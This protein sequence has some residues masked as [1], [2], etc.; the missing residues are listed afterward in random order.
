MKKP[1]LSLLS[2]IAFAACNNSETSN[3]DV[4]SVANAIKPPSN[5]QYNIVAT[6]PHDTASYTQGL[7]WQNNTLYEGTGLEGQSRLLKVDLANGKATQEISLDPSVFGEGITILNDKI[8]QLTWQNHKV[9]VY[10][11]KTFKKV[12]EFAWNH[13][14]WGITHNGSE[15]II[16]TGESNLYVVDPE[17]FKVK[18]IIGVTDNN[19]PLGNLNELEYIDH[20]IYA[21]IYTSDVIIKIDPGSGRVVGK[22]DFS[23]LL[24]KSGK[25]VSDDGNLVLNGIA[26][27]STKNS[28][29]IT[30][31]K[32]PLLF[33]V[34]LP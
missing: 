19:G 28:M 15:L 9:F 22:M 2:V 12:K 11:A 30:G 27:D 31:K 5:I 13:E 10:D 17:S 20:A 26:Y 24:A 1:I 32:W 18:K 21:N 33:E 8:Y 3:D 23:N 6:Y 16:S 4:T 34:K 7:I 29:Y 25:Q 14:G